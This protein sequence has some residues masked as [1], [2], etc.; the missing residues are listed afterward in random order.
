[1]DYMRGW[2]IILK[3]MCEQQGIYPK[4]KKT[5]GGYGCCE[6]C[7]HSYY[8]YGTLECRKDEMGEKYYDVWEDD[9][10]DI[11]GMETDRYCKYYEEYPQED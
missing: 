9:F 5:C 7:I 10:Y 3:T 4:D 8:D 11:T 1:M 2:E 6:H